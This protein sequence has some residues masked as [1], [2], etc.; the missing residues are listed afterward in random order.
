MSLACISTFYFLL[1]WSEWKAFT[2][3][4]LQGLNELAISKILEYQMLI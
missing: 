2:V 3:K 4:Q 1:A